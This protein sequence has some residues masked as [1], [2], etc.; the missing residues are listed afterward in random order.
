MEAV[1]LLLFLSS[2]TLEI[3]CYDDADIH[4]CPDLAA[5]AGPWTIKIHMLSDPLACPASKIEAYAMANAARKALP[6]DKSSN[7]VLWNIQD[8]PYTGGVTSGLLVGNKWF[9]GRSSYIGLPQEYDT[10][11]QREALMHELRHQ[12][13]ISQRHCEDEPAQI[14][15]KDTMLRPTYRL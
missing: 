5:Y 2:M 3:A 13:P 15:I 7:F 10:R 14:C 6:V 12:A 8:C 11:T 1:L 4:Q 9:G